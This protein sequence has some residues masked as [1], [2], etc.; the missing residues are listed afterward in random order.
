MSNRDD[1]LC[2]P[3]LACWQM[4]H[5]LDFT[6]FDAHKVQVAI[7]RHVTHLLCLFNSWISQNS[8]RK[9]DALNG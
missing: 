6:T 5:I 9:I 2:T 4:D 8:I 3:T 1:L 7:W